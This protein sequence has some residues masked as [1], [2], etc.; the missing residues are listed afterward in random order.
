VVCAK[1]CVL[2]DFFADPGRNS[3]PTPAETGCAFG[4]FPK[5][6][7][8]V[9]KTVEIQIDPLFSLASGLPWGVVNMGESEKY[10]ENRPF[11]CCGTQKSPGNGSVG[12]GESSPQPGFLNGQIF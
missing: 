4:L 2:Q 7:T 3:S 6:S 11:R 1:V 5:F 10:C 8:P 9:E 12:R